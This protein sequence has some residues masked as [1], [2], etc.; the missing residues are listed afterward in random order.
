[1]KKHIN[2]FV[3]NRVLRL[4][5]GFLLNAGPGHIH[6]TELDVPAIRVADD[7]DLDYLKARLRLSRTKEGILVQGRLTAGLESECYR[8]LRPVQRVI[9][10]EL[11]ALLA[12]PAVPDCEFS[13][14][15]D[16]I[17]DLVPLVRAEILIEEA[18]GVLCQPDCKGLC[19]ECGENLNDGP[20]QCDTEIID[21]RMAKLKALR[22][23]LGD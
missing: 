1:M 22:D 6:E 15:E 17:L 16:A 8:C 14:G 13:I 23:Q 19:V 5:V 4:N 7:V 21:P 9:T 10:I 11:E 18:H 3:G 12:Y 20:C 2:G